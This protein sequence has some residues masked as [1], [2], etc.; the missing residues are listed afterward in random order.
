[1]AAL[2]A[3]TCRGFR[4]A[5]V[6]SWWPAF[7]PATGN[8]LEPRSGRF[9]RE[10]SP[11]DN[12]R[13]AVKK[14]PEGG[15]ILLRPGIYALAPRK[16]SLSRT[17][18]SIEAPV[19][20]FGRG[21]ATVQ[22]PGCERTIHISGERPVGLCTQFALDGLTVQS[23]ASHRNG[24]YGVLISGGSSRLQSCVITGP[25]Y[26][27]LRI[28]SGGADLPPPVVI[29]CRCGSGKNQSPANVIV[30][31]ANSL[32]CV[33]HIRLSVYDQ[34]YIMLRRINGSTSTGVRI[35]SAARPRLIGNEIWGHG[36]GGI[37]IDFR[38]D[39]HLSGNT[40]RDHEGEEGIGVF[41]GSTAH[42]RATILPDNVFL[43]NEGGDVEREAAPPPDVD[44][45]DDDE[46]D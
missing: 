26:C 31:Y 40:I 30:G 34:S 32:E 14:C 36:R 18:L 15:C 43:R 11:G 45:E 1:M 28:A 44:D 42:S 27:A 33:G 21:Q 9:W 16:I 10:L 13:A 29:N 4:A 35:S 17:G 20:I 37:E 6:E 24:C 8:V 23:L 5:H 22:S 3:C 19:N 25:S 46:D 12:V 2:L 41:V 7:D 38:G 39:P